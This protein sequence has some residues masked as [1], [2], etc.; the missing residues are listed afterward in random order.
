MRPG[1]AQTAGRIDGEK[2]PGEDAGDADRGVDLQVERHPEACER[3][4]GPDRPPRR[5]V[6]LDRLEGGDAAD[7]EGQHLPGV[8]AQ[9]L[10]LL[11]ALRPED[12]QRRADQRRAPAGARPEP[13]E[14]HRRDQDPRRKR[15]QAPGLERGAAGQREE[16]G[17]GAGEPR[18]AGIGAVEDGGAAGLEPAPRREQV[19]ELVELGRPAEHAR[20]EEKRDGEDREGRERGRGRGRGRAAVLDA[21]GDGRQGFRDLQARTGAARAA[22]GT[23]MRLRPNVRASHGAEVN[24]QR[25]R[26]RGRGGRAPGRPGRQAS[27]RRR[28]AAFSG[29]GPVTP[30]PVSR[31]GGLLPAR[32][33]QAAVPAATRGN[34][35]STSRG[36]RRRRSRP[37]RRIP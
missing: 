20:A 2:D 26:G 3:K 1:C 28:R 14:Q 16:P 22:A 4:Q 23:L 17:G 6:P 37:L 10:R 18:G 25:P 8:E 21:V 15:Q 12:R 24:R 9:R 13:Q 30:R 5:P 27:A 33:P 19:V 34:G 31:C 35:A 32:R 11:D 29:T 7:E 36:G